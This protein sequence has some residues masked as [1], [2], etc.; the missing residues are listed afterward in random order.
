MVDSV[1]LTDFLGVVQRCG[2]VAI[3]DNE[4]V[5]SREDFQGRRKRG[6]DELSGFVLHG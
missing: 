5:L 6:P 4:Y 1:L 2:A 3:C